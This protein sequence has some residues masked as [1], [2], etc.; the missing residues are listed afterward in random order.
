MLHLDPFYTCYPSATSCT[1][2]IYIY[3]YILAPIQKQFLYSLNFSG[4]NLEDFDDFCV[5]S[6][7]LVFTG[8]TS[9][10]LLRKFLNLNLKNFRLYGI[11]VIDVTFMVLMVS[12]TVGL[13]LYIVDLTNML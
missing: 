4:E 9:K 12:M 3:I 7:I 5:A 10:I 8:I 1:I 2:Y 13:T 11:S 6:K